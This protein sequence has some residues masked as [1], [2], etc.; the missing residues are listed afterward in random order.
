MTQAVTSLGAAGITADASQFDTS[1]LS[2]LYAESPDLMSGFS[3]PAA[4]TATDAGAARARP[5][6]FPP[7]PEG[8][9]SAFR[10]ARKM[11]ASESNLE[12]SPA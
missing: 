4:A 8:R 3:V 10:R 1:L 5:A 11:Y 12:A 9:A 7:L 2:E 6:S